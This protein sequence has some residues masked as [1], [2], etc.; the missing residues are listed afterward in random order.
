MPDFVWALLIALIV[1]FAVTPFVIILA[2]K[3]GALDAPDA[4]KVHH[5]P[6][7]RIGGI[8]IYL[9][10][11]A[12]VLSVLD[13][14][15][16]PEDVRTGVIGLLV[17]STLIVLLGIVDDYKTLSA[18]VKL[19][20]QIV[21]ASVLVAFGVQIDF[22]ADPFGDYFYLEYFAVPATI[23][24]IVGLTNTVNLIDG[25]D[26]LAAGVATIASI[27]ILLVAIQNDFAL[28]TILT[29]AIAG[30]AIGFL[31]YNFNP[32]KIFM[33]DTGSMFLGFMLAGIS[34]IGAV[35][36]AA[37]IALIV[38]ILALGVPIMDT[39]FAIIRRYRGGVPIFKPDKG[40]LHH[41]LL[42][43]GFNQRQAVLLMYVISA[44][45]GFSAVLLNEVSGGI[46]IAIVVCV[47]LLVFFG[48]KKL[49]I[50]R[51]KNP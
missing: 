40:H 3:T 31:R 50:L 21:A 38:P 41:R 15:S 29:A 13:F 30:A 37:T 43:M 17:S 42:D 9:A 35:K 45:L 49:G 33:G 32:A 47:V 20:G 7:P 12:G 1:A 23:F 4:R 11:M 34:V 19:L 26:G 39:S 36:S 18:K 10:F 25:L 44:L 46:A 48:A 5:K 16:L 28:V 27:T 14:D 6:I 2:G 51:M 24:W 22:I 8:G